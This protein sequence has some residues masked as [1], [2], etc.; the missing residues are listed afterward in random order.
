MV[1]KEPGSE[2]QIGALHLSAFKP[3]DLAIEKPD[4]HVAV[5]GKLAGSLQ[6]LRVGFCINCFIG[7]YAI[8]SI[9]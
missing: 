4:F 5:L 3:P 8:V 2:A 7:R 9:D 1:A 6:R